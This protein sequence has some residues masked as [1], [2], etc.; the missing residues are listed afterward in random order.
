MQRLIGLTRLELTTGNIADQGTDAV[1]NAAHPDLLGG[2]GVDGAIHRFGGP[3]ILDACR[4]IGGCP[5]GNAVITHAGDLPARFVIH[6]VGPVYDPYDPPDALLR[7]AYLNCF[8]IAAAYGL[9]SITFPSISTGAFC[10]PLNVAAPIALGVALKFLRRET[11]NLQLVRF[12]LYPREQPQAHPIF[13]RALENLET[14]TVQLR[15]EK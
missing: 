12:V 9:E 5:V 8:R 7:M 11:H 13:V 4:E 6:A 15:S 1:V 14:A 2:Q 3:R 10:Y